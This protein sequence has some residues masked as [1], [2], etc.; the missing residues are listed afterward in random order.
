GARC[1]A[2]FYLLGGAIAQTPASRTTSVKSEVA[3][4]VTSVLTETATEVAPPVPVAATRSW[5]SRKKAKAVHPEFELDS[6]STAAFQ[7]S[8]PTR[9]NGVNLDVPTFVRRGMPMN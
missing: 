8:E 9:H 2:D 6:G 3:E 5:R 4:R 1:G 7:H